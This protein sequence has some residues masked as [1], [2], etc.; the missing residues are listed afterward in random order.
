MSARRRISISLTSAIRGLSRSYW[1]VAFP[2]IERAFAFLI[3]HPPPH[4]N[5]SRPRRQGRIRAGGVLLGAVVARQAQE[6]ARLP[7]LPLNAQ[8]F[9]PLQNLANCNGAVRSSGAKLKKIPQQVL[10]ACYVRHVD[11]ADKFQNVIAARA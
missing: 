8:R 2:S 5:R 11:A 1:R 7:R 3:F 6:Q 4:I 9:T 10:A